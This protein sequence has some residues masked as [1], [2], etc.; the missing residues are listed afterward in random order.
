MLIW[1]AVTCRLPIEAV[2]TL[3]NLLRVQ[4]Y[5][6]LSPVGKLRGRLLGVVRVRVGGLE[7]HVDHV[8][9]E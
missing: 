5:R 1:L 3:V 8:G 2:R 4:Y 6:L 7:V 9:L